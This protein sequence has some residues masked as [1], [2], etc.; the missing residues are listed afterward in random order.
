ME[1]GIGN[2]YQYDAFGVITDRQEE[3]DNR[4]LYTGQ[5]YDPITEQYYLRARYYNPTVDR[6]LQED[7]YRGDGLNLYAYCENNS[8]VY[9]DPD[10]TN[11]K[12]REYLGKTPGI[13]SKTGREVLDAAYNAG[14]LDISALDKNVAEVIDKKGFKNI[15]ITSSIKEKI[16]FE[17]PDGTVHSLKEAQMAHKNTGVNSK[18]KPYMDAVAAWNTDLKQYGPRSDQARKFMLSSDNY[19]LDYGSNNMST[20][21]KLKMTYDDPYTPLRKFEDVYPNRDEPKAKQKQDNED[22]CKEG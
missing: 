5:Q 13:N 6:F 9:Y 7:V 4:I 14:K 3:F 22:I 17:A 11:K 15:K 18:G 2:R 10:G 21:A 19:E 8:V 16:K 20:G 1:G 12:R